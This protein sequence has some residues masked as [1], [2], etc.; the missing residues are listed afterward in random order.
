M[1][2]LAGLNRPLVH[3]LC[4][5][6][7]LFGARGLLQA[8]GLEAVGLEAADA[9][10][11][12][13]EIDAARISELEDEF[14]GVAGRRP[15]RD[16]LAGL[17]ERAVD[18][19]L[20]YREARARG[21]D[22]GDGGVDARL[23]QKMLFLEQG[24]APSEPADAAALIDR[25]RALGLDREDLVIRRILAEKLRLQ[26]TA[27]AAAETPDE[28]ALR[29]AYEARGEALRTPERRSFVQ[30]F[31]ARDRR[32]A[33]MEQAADEARRRLADEPPAQA[34][35]AR[36]AAIVPGDPFPVGQRIAARTRDELD[37][38]FGAGFG[39]KVF[40]LPQ[41]A[42]SEPIE[43]AYGLQLVSV[44]AI[45]PAEIPPFERVRD[46]LRLEQEEAIRA[47][48]LAA[49]LAELRTRYEVAVA[50]PGEEAR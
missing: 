28:F 5:G 50:W 31:F 26:A 1:R 29:R 14:A 6:A 21:L 38:L 16:E 42:W 12:R 9:A 32:G 39:E 37:R 46:R 49:L 18:E 43:S 35:A 22:A 8:S 4:A 47:R 2:T 3:F 20:L 23:L 44:E 34:V 15:A 17:V 11:A 41:D 27:I 33:P 30:A 40:A 48:K 36:P 24:A 25:A 10:G 19:E 45:L 13:I 7:L